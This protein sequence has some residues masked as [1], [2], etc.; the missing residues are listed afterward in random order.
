MM[1][2]IKAIWLEAFYQAV[3]SGALIVDVLLL[4]CYGPWRREDIWRMFV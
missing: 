2:L 4:S 3:A 1:N